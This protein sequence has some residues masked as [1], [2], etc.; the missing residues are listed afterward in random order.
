MA[1]ADHAL[2]V[3]SYGLILSY[4]DAGAAAPSPIARVDDPHDRLSSY[5]ATTGHTL[6]GRFGDYWIAHGGLM[7]FGY[8][9]TEEFVEQNAIDGHAYLVQYFERAR[10]ELHQENAP[11]YDVLLGLLG[12]SITATRV[13]EAAFQPV[14]NDGSGASYFAETGHHLAPE[15]AAYWQAHGG[16]AIFGYPISEAVEETQEGH[17]YL[18][19]YFE[20]DRFEYH[21]ENSG[22]PYDVLLGRLGAQVLGLR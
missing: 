20:R 8:P 5:F 19:Q 1:D 2:A 18:V 12:R 4:S 11:P 9:L 17:T 6:R 13:G 14:V 22:T 3:G 7:Q 16:L 10:F 21:P 15:F